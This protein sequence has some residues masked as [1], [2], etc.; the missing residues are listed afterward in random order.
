MEEKFFVQYLQNAESYQHVA[1]AVY[2][3]FE[4]KSLKRLIY[5]L[6]PVI[7]LLFTIQR[8]GSQPPWTLVLTGVLSLLFGFLFI[9]FMEK[10]GDRLFCRWYA[11][12]SIKRAAKV[13][14]LCT[15]RF[16]D[17]HFTGESELATSQVQ[18][19]A[20]THLAETDKY[21]LLFSGK[22]LCYPVQKAGFQ[23]GVG[24]GDA[25]KVFIE[26]KCNQKTVY[27]KVY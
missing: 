15:L 10:P 16:Y 5:V 22:V 27:V 9:K 26:E 21:F 7:I 3:L 11:K 2:T 6:L 4:K 14:L 13:D 8:L 18:Y 17:S 25:F 24:N 20:I 12:A 19:G 23:V 1:T